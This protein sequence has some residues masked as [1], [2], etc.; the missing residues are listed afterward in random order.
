M[1]G[2]GRSTAQERMLEA[3]IMT[4]GPAELIEVVLDRA[5]SELERAQALGPDAQWDQVRFH[6][7]RSQRALG[8]LVESLAS[9]DK[10][11]RDAEAR[12]VVDKLGGLYGYVIDNIATADFERKAPSYEPLLK[13]LGEI[14][15]G[16]RKS[17]LGRA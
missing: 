11:A 7:L 15:D 8:L 9:G 4:L 3:S 16:W 2:S 5:I 10:V 13:V 14:S 17:V 1:M 6:L 12:A